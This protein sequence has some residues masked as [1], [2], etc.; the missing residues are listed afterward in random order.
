V[1]ASP[2]GDVLLSNLGWVDQGAIWRLDLASRQQD[3]VPISD[4]TY[5]RL[6]AGRA[7]DSVVAQHG[8]SGR[9]TVSV[10]GWSALADPLVRV[11]VHGW[12]AHVEGDLNAFHG[13][14]RLFV[15][16]MDDAATGAAGYFLIEVGVQEVSI[17]RLDWFDQERYDPKYQQVMSAIEMPTGEYLFGVQR[18]SELVLCDPTDL[19]VIRG[20]S[21]AGRLGNPIP[22]LRADGTEL[23][24]VDYDTV[25]R[26]D[27]RSLIVQDQ[28]L[29]QPPAPTGHRTFLGDLWLSRD[30][31]QLVVARPG[32]GDV[33]SLDPDSLRVADAWVTGREPLTAA[34]VN[35]QLVARDWKT[36]E[37]LTSDKAR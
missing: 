37:L 30:E 13:H 28:G 5:L 27:S 3:R 33:V 24:A 34:I 25:V 22:V 6:L 10:H 26:L 2:A 17:R 19:S 20:V 35:G 36:G 31:R 7:H 8:L 29:G 9:L 1:I 16:Y 4:G 32:S 12:A 18:S 14:G 23:W 21:L 11:D 15:T